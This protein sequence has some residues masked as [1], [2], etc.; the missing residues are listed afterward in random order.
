MLIFFYT[1]P[2]FYVSWYDI[3]PNLFCFP[4]SPYPTAPASYIWFYNSCCI[5]Y[6]IP[7]LIILSYD[8]CCSI[9]RAKLSLCEGPSFYF[10]LFYCLR[11]VK[12]HTPYTPLNFPSICFLQRFLFPHPLFWILDYQ[13]SSLTIRF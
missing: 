11:A 9:S 10:I 1:L 4:P 13:I 12:Q 2:F 6:H 3:I 7:F 5:I 8:F